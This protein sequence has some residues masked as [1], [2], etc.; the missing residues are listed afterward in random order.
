MG[1]VEVRV[2][3]LTCLVSERDDLSLLPALADAGVDG[4]QVRAKSLDGRA[5]TALV[6]R[7]VGAVRPEGAMV[8]VNDRLD[9]ALAG[10]ADG[11]HLGRVDVPVAAARRI[12]PDLVV[13][14]TCRTRAEVE[15]AARDGASY[16]G[17]GP[18]FAT[19]SK[20]GLPDPL[21]P[22]AVSA[23]AGVLPLVAIG[24][25][26]AARVAAVVAAGA[27]GVAVIGGI[28]RQPDPVSAAKEIASQ[29]G[30]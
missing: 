23:A 5:L 15:S 10:G 29:L 21:G 12:A 4:F 13:G 27:H 24:G 7:V 18:V 9:V 19:A 6:E 11:V 1:P 22:A 2:P 28:W 16:A 20:E 8:L 17:F 25:I 30:G 26:D 14:A 3:R